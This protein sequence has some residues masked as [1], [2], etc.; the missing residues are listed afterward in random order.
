MAPLYKRYIPPRPSSATPA[1]TSSAH[2]IKVV[3][4]VA[5]ADE[6]KKRKRERTD[7][8]IAERKAKKLRKRGIDPAFVIRQ[9]V[10]QATKQPRVEAKASEPTNGVDQNVTTDVEPRG[11]FAHV[12]NSKK[13]H[14]L[15]KEARKARKAAGKNAKSSA[16]AG[17]DLSVEDGGNAVEDQAD[18]PKVEA[19][20][21][22]Y[23]EAPAVT[24]VSKRKKR[25][26]HDSEAG[27]NGDVNGYEKSTLLMV[28]WNS[29][30]T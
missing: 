7:D 22:S 23:P 10:S 3:P 2:P 14:K 4:A 15:E 17:D 8:E 18:L 24:E 5:P 20:N 25:R 11:D 27:A 28:L 21:T 26:K 16:A 12:K 30:R 6:P 9:E 13:R 19:K 29:R 1:V